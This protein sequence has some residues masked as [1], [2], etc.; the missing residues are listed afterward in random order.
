MIIDVKK[1]KNKQIDIEIT[2]DDF[3]VNKH[4]KIVATD[5]SKKANIPGFRKGKVPYNIIE[6]QYGKEYILENSLD[7]IIQEIIPG[8]LEE[9]KL[10][11]PCAPKVDI[12]EREPKLK[13]ILMVP[14]MPEI[15]LGDVN[16]LTSKI[17][18]EKI[19]KNKIDET[20]NRILESRATWGI[21]KLPLDLPG[22]AKLN[23][24]GKFEDNEI[25]SEKDF[26]FYAAEN[27]PLVAPGISENIKGIKKGEKKS[28]LLTLPLDWKEEEYKGK[29]I[30]FSV[31]CLEIQEKI[32]PKLDDKFLKELNPEI[33]DLNEFQ[34]QIKNEVKAEND[35]KYNL[36]MENQ[37][38]DDM[39]AISK[40]MISEIHIQRSADHVIEDR[41]KS[42]SQ[43]R[44]SLDDYLKAINKTN[45]EF[46]NEAKDLSEKEL[47]KL[48][49]IDEL[50]KIENIKA[51][52]KDIENEIN[53]IKE[54]YK[55][56]KIADDET[57]F[58]IV[59]NNIK[60]RN[61]I[62]HLI[63]IAKSS[64]KNRQK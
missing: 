6:S 59:E 46:Y 62:E 14:L 3:I 12:L 64:D 42:I 49:I 19:T 23:I 37:A 47:K 32:I 5:I 52:K 35:Y 21:S 54:Q 24:S 39:I 15:D 28:F 27:S 48:L 33:K 10:E 26:D 18:K 25:I 56:Q 55:G 16:S 50:I 29:N 60:R 30:N 9:Q 20:I 43:Y 34:E 57:L 1:E 61:S 22:F 13:I 44:M 8:I 2:I 63:N 31:E 45:E 41:M 53:S 36:E 17:K 7:P 11:Y 40:F 4:L 38:I 58:S 51:S